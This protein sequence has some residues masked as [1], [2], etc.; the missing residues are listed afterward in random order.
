MGHQHV[1]V[2]NLLIDSDHTPCITKFDRCPEHLI[3]SNR[4]QYKK[5]HYSPRAQ[6]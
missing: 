4:L 2:A 1:Y 5:K 6:L 3:F